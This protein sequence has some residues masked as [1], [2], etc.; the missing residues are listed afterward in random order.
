MRLEVGIRA[1]E[2]IEHIELE[3]GDEDPTHCSH[4][5]CRTVLIQKMPSGANREACP[6]C[7]Q[8]YDVW[9]PKTMPAEPPPPPDPP[10]AEFNPDF[11]TF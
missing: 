1:W 7:Q 6:G 4:C 9:E 3:E 11:G 8:H 2:P 10:T 5:S